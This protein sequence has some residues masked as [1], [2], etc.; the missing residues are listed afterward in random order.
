MASLRHHD[1]T[2]RKRSRN[3]GKVGPAEANEVYLNNLIVFS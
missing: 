3:E 2:G 1:G